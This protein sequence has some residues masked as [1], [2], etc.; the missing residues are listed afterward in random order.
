MSGRAVVVA[1]AAG[2]AVVAALLCELRRRR[3]RRAA[4]AALS[5]ARA[6]FAPERP[7]TAVASL[8]PF[9]RQRAREGAGA[10]EGDVGVLGRLW[11]ACGPRALLGADARGARSASPLASPQFGRATHW[12]HEAHAA[13]PPHQAALHRKSRARTLPGIGAM[14]ERPS[15]TDLR[16]GGLTAEQAKVHASERAAAA[17]AASGHQPHDAGV[18][19]AGAQRARGAVGR[20]G[21]ASGAPAGRA[22]GGGRYMRIYFGLDIGGSLAKIVHFEPR[23]KSKASLRRLASFIRASSTYET[24]VRDVHLQLGALQGTLHFIRFETRRMGNFLELVRAE[25]LQAEATTIYATGGGAHKFAADFESQLGVTLEKLDELACCVKGVTWL[26]ANVPDELFEYRE[27]HR[28]RWPPAQ[29]GGAPREG[30]GQGAAGAA[31]GARRAAPGPAAPGPAAPGP[32]APG[33]AA[34]G[35]AA[36]GP[37]A[38]GS[39]APGPAAPGLAAPAS[40]DARAA[41]SGDDDDDDDAADYASTAGEAMEAVAYQIP[42]GGTFPFILVNIG[43]GVSILRIRSEDDFE[44][45]SGTAV[46]GGTFLGLCRLLGCGDTFDEALENAAGGDDA[47]VNL[48]VEDI[49]GGGGYDAFGLPP[50]LIASMFGKVLR[51]EDPYEGVGKADVCRALLVMISQVIAQVAYLSALNGG[52]SR[53]VFSGTFLHS[54]QIALRTLAYYVSRWSGGSVP[55]LFLKHEGYSGA[56]GAFLFS[57][58]LDEA[59]GVGAGGLSSDDDDDVVDEAG[60]HGTGA[61]G[62]DDDGGDGDG[63]GD[64]GGDDDGGD[65]D[66][67]D[68]DGA[69]AGAPSR[70]PPAPAGAGGGGGIARSRA[71]GGGGRPSGETAPA[72]ASARPSSEFGA[73]G[74]AGLAPPAAVRGR[75]ASAQSTASSAGGTFDNEWR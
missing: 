1:A 44:R 29:G 24:G 48:L 47:K 23:R 6:R 70:P 75:A 53:L 56:L 35:P 46:G 73:G 25:R 14:A 64:D 59:Y 68:G 38:P 22:G 37:A 15:T 52:A 72:G 19:S 5:R 16:R 58:R 7:P 8:A 55:A 34:P 36:P 32:A 41:S 26:L 51:R 28:E 39:A 21:G 42:E 49:Y 9:G 11:R 17:A 67:G 63:G 2:I 40:A 50:K 12:P 3:R 43:S 61:N 54:N 65:G 74:G 30:D 4:T 31:G 18:A 57:A 71:G 45:V 27:Q 66:G 13:S 33:P 62:D 10:D 20:A 69:A 60:A